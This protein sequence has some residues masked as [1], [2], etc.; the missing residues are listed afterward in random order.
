[1]RLRSLLTLASVAVLWSVS[2]PASWAQ[3]CILARQRAPVFGVEGPYLPAGSL[4]FNE[5]FRA[6]NASRH[7]SGTKEQTVRRDFANQVQNEQRIMDAGFTYGLTDSTSIALNVPYLLYGSWSVHL[8]IGPPFQPTLTKGP[9]YKQTAEG[10]GDLRLVARRWLFEPASNPDANVQLGVGIKAPTGDSNYTQD[11]PDLFGKHIHERSVDSSIQPGDGGWGLVVD[12]QSFKQTEWCT[13]YA[14]GTYLFNPQNTN[15]THS[16]VYN[17]IGPTAT[18]PELA[19]N[20][21]SDQYLF[22]IGA[23]KSLG[24]LPGVATSLAWRI[25]G[26]PPEDL[27]GKSEG[28]RRPGYATFVEPGISYTTGSTTWSFSVPFTLIANRQNNFLDQ[29]GDATFADW[30]IIVGFQINL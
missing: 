17:L 18:V 22:V 29:P 2:A 25:E 14:A 7:F 8:P 30:M 9:R 4:Q 5:G 11:F 24:F 6:L 27:I 13:F 10:L 12:M 1:M 16:I 15:N 28:W 26:I 3:G 21:I 20:S 19:F 23:A